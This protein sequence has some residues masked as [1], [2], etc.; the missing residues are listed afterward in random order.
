MEPLQ[1][2]RR[3]GTTHLRWVPPDQPFHARPVI[4]LDPDGS[5]NAEAT[6]SL[7]AEHAVSV[8][9]IEEAAPPEVPQH[10]A[11]KGTACP[12]QA[13]V[14]EF[15]PVVGLKQGG[16]VKADL[17]VRT[18]RERAVEYDTVVVE[19][20]VECRAES[21]EEADRPQLAI[22]GRA[23]ARATQGRSNGAEEDS[24]DGARDV[25]IVVEEGSPGVRIVVAWSGRGF[26]VQSSRRRA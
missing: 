10:A 24:E 8:G 13:V 5:I 11:L 25:R 19:V 15:L 9:F 3:P 4:A 1:G 23:W 18:L 12:L 6:G 7:P 21:M 2:E 26:G 22:P 16:L 14:L 17:T 20:R